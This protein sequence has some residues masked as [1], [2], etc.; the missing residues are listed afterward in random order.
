MSRLLELTAHLCRWGQIYILDSLLRYVPQRHTDAE[1]VAERIIVQ[2]QHANSAVV[3]TTIKVLLYLM[4][5]MENRRLMDYC[6]KKMGPP[7]GML[8]DFSLAQT[9]PH[10]CLVTLLSSGPEVQYVALRN[11]LLIIQ[12][13]PAV[14]KNDVR[15]FF[16][17]YNDPIYVKLAK[18]EIM[19]RLARAENANEVLAELQEYV[20]FYNHSIEFN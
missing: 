10:F 2:L 20:L 3:L 9:K 18:L 19:Y 1:T 12:R 5:Y 7:L 11:I 8:N 4:N 16:C 6:C 13:R 14:L 15:V 17:K